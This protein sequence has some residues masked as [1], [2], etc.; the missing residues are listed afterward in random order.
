M[1]GRIP[2]NSFIRENDPKLTCKT[3]WKNIEENILNIS[4]IHI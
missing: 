1:N 4:G 3:K 2:Y